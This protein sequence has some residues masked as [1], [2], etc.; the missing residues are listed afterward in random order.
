MMPE[1][2]TPP[3]P[4]PPPPR[5]IVVVKR[6]KKAAVGHHGG[7]WKVAY[8]DFVTSLMALFIVLWLMS[9]DKEVREQISAFFNDSK[10]HR[11]GAGQ[12][13]RRCGTRHSSA[14][15]R[16]EQTAREDPTGAGQ[17]AGLP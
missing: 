16:P 1:V 4:P 6:V 7:A 14:Q 17:H 8:T 2:E 13:G 3:P 9:A 5:P 15:R 12:C 10:R 11:K